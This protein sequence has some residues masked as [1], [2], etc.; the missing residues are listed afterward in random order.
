MLEVKIVKLKAMYAATF[1]GFGESP[2]QIAWDKLMAWAK[3]KGLLDD[4]KA[5][6]I[7]GYNNPP[8]S[9]KGTK[10]GYMLW[11]KVEPE[12]EPEDDMRVE[13]FYGGVYA[14][15]KC[16][17]DNIRQTWMEL[18]K[19]AEEN[20]HKHSYTPG[21]EKTLDS[22]ENMTDPSKFMMELYLPTA[23]E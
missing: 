13:L 16:T 5:H 21:L 3:P 22:I 2:E 7:Y 17:L 1:Y 18:Y 11:I 4:L 12:T 23:K 19:W 9:D 8:P 10:Y 15:T 14:V 6:P 20:G